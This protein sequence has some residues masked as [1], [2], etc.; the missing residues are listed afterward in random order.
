MIKF[1]VLH[2]KAVSAGILLVRQFRS[3]I[4]CL[5]MRLLGINIKLGKNLSI[6]RM[7]QVQ[8]TDRGEIIIGDGVEIQDLVVLCA[9]EGTI[10]IGNNTFIGMGTQ[11]TAVSSIKIGSECLIAAY[12]VIRDANHGMNHGALMSKQP[13]ASSP[14]SIGDDVWLGA[15]V[16]VTAGSIIGSGAVIG[17][18]AVVTGKIQEFSV[19]VGVPAKTIKFR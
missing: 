15:H 8:V 3:R 12:S 18:N 6:G 14:I 10:Q 13:S 11:L 7:V 16:V 17:A 1:S 5:K 2:R 4:F 19:A 9:K